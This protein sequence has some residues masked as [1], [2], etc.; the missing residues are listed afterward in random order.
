MKQKNGHWLGLHRVKEPQ[1]LL[2]QPAWKLNPEPVCHD[3]ELLI[4]VDCLNI[5][6]ASFHQIKEGAQG[7]VERVKEQIFAIVQERGKMHNPVTG[8]GGML[9]GR[10]S[11]VGSLFPA[12]NLQTGTRIATLVS[13]SLTPLSLACIHSVDMETGQVE[14][15]GRAILFASAPYAVLP[16]DLPEQIT[17][18]VLDVCG[19]PAQVARLTQPGQRVAVLGAGGK[20][21]LLSLYHARKQAGMD[22]QVLALESREKAC[23]EIHE[24]GLADQ[25]IQ[26]D[27]RNP[28]AV[29]EA[30]TE[31]TDGEMADLTINCVNVRD[32]EL[33]AILATRDGGTVYFFSTA[34]QFTAAAL[35]AEGVGKDVHMMIGN[36]YAPGHADLALNTLRE[37]SGLRAV[38]ESRYRM[39][40]G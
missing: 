24:L 28:V 13:L 21:G 33:S 20:S 25:V 23:D 3:N 31:A 27:A 18:A 19:A 22:G 17:L 38:F 10:V 12:G 26:V 30:V 2:P 29:L 4:E 5:D 14:V 1:G 36:G 9:I 7:D 35:G 39:A 6:S 32:T 16:D 40:T 15:Q 34:V 11:E 37:S 8:S